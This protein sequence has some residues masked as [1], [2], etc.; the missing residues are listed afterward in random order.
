MLLFLRQH[1]WR[2]SRERVLGDWQSSGAPHSTAH[3]FASSACL[4]PT[5]ESPPVLDEQGL[6][7]RQLGEGS[8]A[9]AGRRQ[10]SSSHCITC[11]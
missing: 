1:R 6:R 3:L 10:V 9:G 2:P 5:L 8:G 4:P 11:I 7:S